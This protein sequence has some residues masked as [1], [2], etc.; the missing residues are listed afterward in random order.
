MIEEKGYGMEKLTA[1]KNSSWLSRSGLYAFGFYPQGKGYAVGIF[2]TGIPE[3]TVAWTANQDDPPLSSNDTLLL[4][5][6]GRLVLQSTEGSTSIAKISK[7]AASASML[8]SGNFVLYNT[9]GGKYG[10]FLITQ[11]I[12]FCKLKV[13]SQGRSCFQVFQELSIPG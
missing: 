13:S 5:S 10:K 7:P 12:L 11:M 2:L 9:S 8:D 3:K 1:R 4:N 6:G